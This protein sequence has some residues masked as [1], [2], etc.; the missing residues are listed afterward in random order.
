MQHPPLK[1][2]EILKGRVD[3]HTKTTP[4]TAEEAGHILITAAQSMQALSFEPVVLNQPA[5]GTVML[6][7]I[8]SH[9][10]V[11]DGYDWSA[12]DKNERFPLDASRFVE[13]IENTTGKIPG[14]HHYTVGRRRFKYHMNNQS[15]YLQLLQY[16]PVGDGKKYQTTPAYKAP[17]PKRQQQVPFEVEPPTMNDPMARDKLPEQGVLREIAY[18][19]YNENYMLLHSVFYPQ[20][21]SG[22]VVDVKKGIF[23]GLLKG[24]LT[25]EDTIPL[26][27]QRIKALQ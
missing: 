16:F 1:A 23:T 14:K 3:Y 26:L 21:C 20:V 17:E 24:D 7:I 12:K 5:M 19:R 10:F 13:V 4:L 25:E 2:N 8:H 27:E 11:N 22:V 9:S 6:T 15:S 18:E